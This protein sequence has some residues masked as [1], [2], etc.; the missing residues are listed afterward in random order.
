MLKASAAHSLYY[1]SRQQQQH[2][3]QH[4]NIATTGTNDE[5]MCRNISN[6]CQKLCFHD[7]AGESVAAT[8]FN[9]PHQPYHT[10]NG[11]RLS[12]YTNNGAHTTKC[13]EQ[14]N[15]ILTDSESSFSSSS[16]SPAVPFPVQITPVSILDASSS[17]ESRY[18]HFG[19]RQPQS[20]NTYTNYYP[21][22]QINDSYYIKPRHNNNTP[23]DMLSYRHKKVNG[24]K[25]HS[26]IIE[27]KNKRDERIGANHLGYTDDIQVT[28]RLPTYSPPHSTTS[29]KS[30]L[31]S[32][33]RQPA[34]IKESNEHDNY[35]QQR[36]QIKSPTVNNNTCLLNKFTQKDSS[37]SHGLNSLNLVDN[38]NKLVADSATMTQQ[39]QTAMTKIA[40]KGDRTINLKPA[41]TCRC[42]CYVNHSEHDHILGLDRNDGSGKQLSTLECSQTIILNDP[43]THNN[44]DK[45][46]LKGKDNK[47]EKCSIDE[48]RSKT[49]D[50]SIHC[51]LHDIVSTH[52]IK[53]N[54]QKFYKLG[55][56]LRSGGFSDIYEGTCL[57]NN[58][59]VIL[60]FIPKQKT[61]NWLLIQGK[62]YPSEVLLHKV[63]S[64]LPGIL[65]FYDYFEEK[66]CWVI[67]IEKLQN[68]CDLFDYMEKMRF[69]RLSE[70]AARQ[71]FLQL[72]LA[73]ID[74][75][76]RGVVHRDIKSENI[77]LDIDKNKLVLI[78]FGAS[79][80]YQ[81]EVYT[82]FHG[83]RQFSTPEYIKWSKYKA[84]PST[85]WTLGVLLYD[86]VIGRLPFENDKDIL[87]KQIEIAAPIS[88]QLRTLINR[89]LHK[90]P[91]KRPDLED[92]LN[93][94]WLINYT[95]SLPCTKKTLINEEESVRTLRKKEDEKTLIM[96]IANNLQSYIYFEVDLKDFIG[97]HFLKK[98]IN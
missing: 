23:P 25:R 5:Q 95:L 66:D 55:K 83:T 78:D 32:C 16:N 59:Q 67:V 51:Y 10:G 62:D 34:T 80:I 26:L 6:D 41:S 96:N 43:L 63:V 73:N 81:N 72:T 91:E 17:E 74:L 61:K 3:I 90:N 82:D 12:H 71:F 4:A 11:D 79:A 31:S 45:T 47:I 27:H 84:M 64:D 44:D 36:K 39:S 40:N 46:L 65:N 38:K 9:R 56:F 52:K 21:V 29:A 53:S 86:M 33:G 93:D 50:K 88:C 7:G 76:R 22:S 35:R 20:T 77:L 57:I 19:R 85:V 1:P 70:P 97:S 15:Q 8:T 69:G 42:S 60:K 87:A 68:C 94:P 13:N 75:T 89:C 28:E 14:S 37:I 92:L 54:Y 49:N 24:L 2:T 48:Y 58:C 18:L 98:S 30:I